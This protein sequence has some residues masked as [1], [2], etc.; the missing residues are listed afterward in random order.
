MSFVP[1]TVETG[2]A[3]LIA[4]P[5]SPPPPVVGL[6]QVE[7]DQDRVALRLK[8]QDKTTKYLLI[9]LFLKFVYLLQDG[10]WWLSGRFGAL[11]PEGRRFESHSNH[12]VRILSKSFTRG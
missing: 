6:G 5:P 1:C 8:V 11:R 4:P 2:R 10:S 9:L 3:A 7:L 12:H